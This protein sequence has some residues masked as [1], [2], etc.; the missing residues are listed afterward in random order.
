M[1]IRR[2]LV[3]AIIGLSVAAMWL[4]EA[5]AQDAAI[6]AYNAYLQAS[7]VGDQAGVDAALA[8]LNAEC[9]ALG[10][11]DPDV[12][13]AA[14]TAPPPPE[15]PA[16]PT[17]EE[18]AAQAL[19]QM[20]NELSGPL[21]DYGLAYNQAV[22]GGDY[23]QAQA[24][25]QQAGQQIAQIC[26]NYGK[27]SIAEC[28]GSELPAF[29]A[30][31]P[32][33]PTQEELDARFAQE[34]VAPLADYQTALDMAA[35]GGDY[36]Q[37]LALANDAAARLAQLC[38]NY[39]RAAD[40][41]NCVGFAL[42]EVPQPTQGPT[43]EELQQQQF[44]AD[45]QQAYAD[46]SGAIAQVEAG[47]DYDAWKAAADDAAAR[48]LQICN[49]NNFA[50]I[51]DCIQQDL[52]PF[53]GRPQAGGGAEVA[54]TPEG[55]TPPEAAPGPSQDEII[56]GI[57]QAYADYMAAYDAAVAGGD[58]AALQR[59]AADAAARLQQA[60]AAYGAATVVDCIQTEL[61]PM[62]GGPVQT[63]QP[64]TPT[65]PEAP[66]QPTADDLVAQIQAAYAD[67]MTAYNAAVN[68]GDLA[69]LQQAA[70]V[71]ETRLLQACA[72]YGAPTVVDC[73][74]QELPVMP[75][76][77]VQT[78]RPARLDHPEVDAAYSEYVGIYNE[79]VFGQ[80]RPLETL[81]PLA[82]AALA[83]LQ[84]VCAGFG[85]PNVEDCL[86]EGVPPMPQSPEQT[87]GTPETP[88]QPTTDE[89]IAQIQAA[90][91]DYMAAYGSA[92]NGVGDFAAAHQTA[93]EA[94]SRLQ[95]ACTAYGIPAIVD[96]I[97]TDLPP[98]PEA[99][100]Q[101]A[102]TPNDRHNPEV[103]A[104]Y[105]EYVGVHNE[106]VFGQGRPLETL[107]PLADAALAQLQQVC[108]NLGHANVEDCLGEGVPPM[109][110]L[111]EQTAATPVGG[112]LTGAQGAID[113]TAAQRVA[114]AVT[115]YNANIAT[116]A[117]AT[118]LI[119]DL[120]AACHDAGF[121]AIDTCMAA[122][123]STLIATPMP[124]GYN[125]GELRFQL[126]QAMA[127]FQANRALAIQGDQAGYLAA[128]QG[129]VE[130]RNLCG[131]LGIGFTACVGPDFNTDLT[132]QG[133]QVA[134]TPGETIIGGAVDGNGQQIELVRT[135]D[136]QG[137]NCVDSQRVAAPT[138][139][140]DTQAAAIAQLQPLITA[141]NANMA[142]PAPG[143]D[144]VADLGRIKAICNAAGLGSVEDCAVTAGIP[145][146]M[147]TRGTNTPE[148]RQQLS[149]ALSAYKAAVAAAEAG[150]DYAT[151]K[152]AADDTGAQVVKICAIMGRPILGYCIGQPE[153]PPFPEPT[154][155]QLAAMAPAEPGVVLPLPGLADGQAR[156]STVTILEG[157]IGADDKLYQKVRRCDVTTCAETIEEPANA[158][159]LGQVAVLVDDYNA[160]ID[161]PS[162]DAAAAKLNIVSLCQATGVGD[163][164]DCVG[165]T[166]R[167]L[168]DASGGTQV[169][170]GPG[171]NED[172]TLIRD[173]VATYNANVPTL[174]D[175]NFNRRETIFRLS[176]LCNSAGFGDRDDCLRNL[177]LT[178]NET[179]HEQLIS[180]AIEQYS[181]GAAALQAGDQSGQSTVDREAAI[182][183]GE[184]GLLGYTEVD[185]C[186]S[187]Y[188]MSLPPLTQ[189]GDGGAQVAATPPTD[190][191]R[192]QYA[193]ITQLA[194]QGYMDAIN[195]LAIGGDYA[196]AKDTALAHLAVLQDACTRLGT[197]DI[198]ACIGRTLPPFPE[199]AVA[200]GAINRVFPAYK[201]Y[202][203]TVANLTG[204]DAPDVL[205]RLAETRTQ[206]AL[207]CQNEGLG[208]I[209]EDC[210]S[211]LG[212]PPPP[213]L[214]AGMQMAGATPSPGLTQDQPL[215]T[216]GGGAPV[217][218]DAERVAQQGAASNAYAA[219]LK[220]IED[221][222]TDYVPASQRAQIA[223][224]DLEKA[225][226]ALGFS[227]FDCLAGELP[228]F[229]PAPTTM[230]TATAGL[231]I[232]Q[233][234]QLQA[235]ISQG[236]RDYADAIAEAT[237]GDYQRARF[238]AD[239]AKAMIGNACAALGAPTNDP[240]VALSEFPP[241]PGAQ[242]ATGGPALPAGGSEQSRTAEAYAKL[243]A[244]VEDYNDK[245]SRGADF[246]RD[247]AKAAMA[248]FCATNGLS[249]N[250][251]QCLAEGG[252]VVAE[253]LAGPA[254]TVP[255]LALAETAVSPL[256]PRQIRDL[257]LAQL[258]PTE[259]RDVGRNI[260]DGL[261]LYELGV[262]ETNSGDIA[263]GQRDIAAATKTLTE[264]CGKI[265][266]DAMTTCP[267]AYGK[268]LP[269]TMPAGSLEQTRTAEAH[270]KL[271]AM[272]EDYNGKASR[273]A[274]FDRD[275]AK[276]AMTEF[277]AANGLSGNLYQCLAEGGMVMTDQVI[278]S[279]T[280]EV[281][282]TTVT[283]G[284]AAP[285]LDSV[286]GNPVTTPATT[287]VA[288][289][290][291]GTPPVVTPL[292]VPVPTTDADAQVTL[293]KVA[294][295]S[296]TATLGT[297]IAGNP[298]EVRFTPPVI[299][300]VV[301][302]GGN[303]NNGF[304]L[305]VGGNLTIS[306]PY[307]DRGR[308]FDSSTDQMSYE[309]LPNGQ[310]RE[311]VQRPNGITVVTIR[312]PDGDIVRRSRFDPDGQEFILAV[313]RPDDLADDDEWRDP[314]DDLPPM[315]LTIPAG[316]YVF[317]ADGADVADISFFL[318]QPPVERVA[319]MYTIDE[320]KRSARVRDSVRRL[321]LGD[322]TFASGKAT[323]G[324]DQIRTLED[325][326]DAMLE[327][328]DRDPAETFLV[329]G[330]TDAV[331]DELFNLR[332][333]DDRANEVAT[334][335][336]EEYGVPPENLVTQG[337]GESFLKVMT[338][339]SE[340]LN[341]RVT[342]RRITPLITTLATGD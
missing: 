108:T 48:L 86:G 38:I 33:G 143:F 197:P 2:W 172:A 272:L 11:A 254:S 51:L 188:G 211:A 180:E 249:S 300:N 310:V 98:M 186:L 267:A 87:A 160:R 132:P 4:G 158:A 23:N 159:A 136:A 315:R 266:L 311:T 103:E 130:I 139:Q 49:A 123:G 94:R 318:V 268:T 220:A 78:A 7:S 245:A 270:A 167:T 225:C 269:V 128:M 334:I 214:P 117:D 253:A 8:Q 13:V 122:T 148:V 231:S 70:G 280:T 255:V 9:G 206:F 202:H 275:A 298:T 234:N 303:T 317:D 101:T 100:V 102:G 199:Q 271:R 328:L 285:L 301:A 342:F 262:N 289:T 264:N 69:A 6:A 43:A 107:I 257:G 63:A 230:T 324:R 294:L 99:P 76:A 47:A 302:G 193:R 171:T 127:D 325:V 238:K 306:N 156:L 233:W 68:G 243:R 88:A 226:T 319:R 80:G 198:A 338:E 291:P 244:M 330:H 17:P 26:A 22:G 183:A 113:P 263:A 58:L 297:G 256:S 91:A 84:Q 247:A 5:A 286:K 299:G 341:R 29:P 77:P 138:Q 36:N 64:E 21:N 320:V 216:P 296:I 154:A 309:Q 196:T 52:P 340:R 83:Q 265:G 61:P 120:I 232:E 85:Q 261:F 126:S 145:I 181:V 235:Q 221:A 327:L 258:S 288:T 114:G 203:D 224:E 115:N 219:Y 282:P 252:I 79:A 20:Q 213:P 339:V 331:G 287:T 12:C 46:Y 163:L 10:Y 41:V 276:A 259:A 237:T 218:T 140:G 274:D 336:S 205:T 67:Y 75:Q 273:G 89:L 141:F 30:P 175:P 40:P 201:A 144:S 329:E 322:L 152:A 60:C 304:V 278:T 153:L 200:S 155:A 25:A 229:P 39:G 92:T 106:A 189:Q 53:P 118:V 332:L 104:A 50:T 164:S 292:F 119:S 242:V 295:P 56:A 27:A 125:E 134:G 111:P 45:A 210:I 277:C 31:P 308:L 170:V 116:A 59:A 248:E 19:Q 250:L 96:C 97:Q 65:A 307:S 195:G 222:A 24:V 109:P 93:G 312:K 185:T 28:I 71:A 105:G 283:T 54:T 131:I 184:C 3:K 42:P 32:T 176:F 151:A 179:P 135:C 146:T 239:T 121:D 333:S 240:C 82:E 124:P 73:I 1:R 157:L 142:N 34:S 314:G 44:V 72:D 305:N 74:Q 279:N 182:I 192:S 55:G 209:V 133:T 241:A 223:R 228:P 190:Q 62:P 316:D 284:T 260:L 18:L 290:G 335:L 66:A 173:L 137:L 15:Q 57:Q 90:Y 208:A 251:Y 81:R 174:R 178:L 165:Q 236:M 321:E 215:A 293:P 323:L 129:F 204:N 147:V 246:D 337:Y 110:K 207:A 14:I 187:G 149:A 191:E 37:A 161:D 35:N 168:A 227:L 194:S 281:L 166:G 177:G 212:L 217:L 95:E 112:E 326:A 16:G 169:A 162:F 150:G 313:G